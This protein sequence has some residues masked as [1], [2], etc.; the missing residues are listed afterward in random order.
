[1]VYL[2]PHFKEEN[3]EIGEEYFIYYKEQLRKEKLLSIVDETIVKLNFTNDITLKVD[4]SSFKDIESP[5]DNE[6]YIVKEIDS[7]MFFCILK[8]ETNSWKSLK[9]EDFV[10]NVENLTENFKSIKI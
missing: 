4:Y 6:I 5:I 2:N 7:F 1:M 3:I 8:K 10:K 9:L